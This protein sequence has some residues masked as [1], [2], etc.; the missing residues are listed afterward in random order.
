MPCISFSLVLSNI[1]VCSNS[2]SSFFCAAE[3]FYTFVWNVIPF[4]L[5]LQSILCFILGD[6]GYASLTL[7]IG[8]AWLYIAPS[9]LLAIYLRLLFDYF[10]FRQPQLHL[11]SLNVPVQF[12]VL[13]IQLLAQYFASIVQIFM[14][15][16]HEY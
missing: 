13:D 6:S 8:A 2:L 7:C 11:F 15:I 4:K 3:I 9:M 16:N 10:Y 5:V 12:C 1:R 14:I